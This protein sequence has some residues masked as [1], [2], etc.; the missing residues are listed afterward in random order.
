[1][2]GVGS[3]AAGALALAETCGVWR[4]KKCKNSQRSCRTSNKVTPAALRYFVRHLIG[5]CAAA[6]AS[7]LVCYI[8]LAAVLAFCL[9]STLQD[10][11]NSPRHR[12]LPLVLPTEP[13]GK[14]TAARGPPAASAIPLHKRLKTDAAAAPQAAPRPSINY[15]RHPRPH[16][17][18]VDA[19]EDHGLV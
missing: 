2:N 9:Y 5:M 16:Q 7:L 3:I 17:D 15:Q 11:V 4:G 13:R 18:A 8:T 19:L 1:M 10:T 14:S 12:G 6:K